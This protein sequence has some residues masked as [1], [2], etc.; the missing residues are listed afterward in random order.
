[1]KKLKRQTWLKP[2]KGKKVANS[3]TWW[4]MKERYNSDMEKLAKEEGLDDY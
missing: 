4:E 1:M 2:N 3:H